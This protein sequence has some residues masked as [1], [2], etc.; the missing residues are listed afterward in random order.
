MKKRFEIFLGIC[1]AVFIVNFISIKIAGNIIKKELIEKFPGSEIKFKNSGL[2]PLGEFKLFNCVVRNNNDSF[3]RL[4]KLIVYYDLGIFL[5]VINRISIQNLEINYSEVKEDL[6]NFLNFPIKVSKEQKKSFVIKAFDINDGKFFVNL[7][8]FNLNGQLSLDFNFFPLNVNDFL[9]EVKDFKFNQFKFDSL[10]FIASHNADSGK[11]EISN[12]SYQDKIRM[13]SLSA[14]PVLHADE[15]NFK[16]IKSDFVGNNIAGDLKVTLK[17]S[18]DYS[19]NLK[20]ENFNTSVVVDAF[21]LKKRFDLTGSFQGDLVVVGSVLK[22]KNVKAIKGNL[23]SQQL[24]GELIILD[25]KFLEN[26][27]QSSK[28]PLGLIKASFGN[29][30][31]DNGVLNVYTQNRNLFFNIS[32]DGRQGKRNLEVVLHD[33]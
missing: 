20:T 19:L 28:Q 4:E 31:Y 8:D 14:V 30:H 26:L 32:F 6:N 27:A 15:L 24:G 12:I 16:D 11:F 29:Y 13:K 9:L 17:D 23:N 5:K 25:Q 3:V 18:F 21:D 7:K 33:Y 10:N 2:V 22:I 1:V